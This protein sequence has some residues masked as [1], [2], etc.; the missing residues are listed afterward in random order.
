MLFPSWHH[1]VPVVAHRARK[2]DP[3]EAFHLI[4]K[5]RIRNAFMPPTALKMMRQVENPGR[6]HD[7][8]MRS[9]GCGGETLGAELLEWGK[10]VMG[11]TINEFYGQTEVNLVVGNCAEIMEIR[12]GSMGKPI[13]GHVAR[14]WMNPACRC[15]RVPWA[16]FPSNGPTR[17]CSFGSWDNLKATEE[18]YVGDWCLTGDLV[19]KDEDG[20]IWFVGRKDD[21]ITSE[22]YRIG[23]RRSKIA[24]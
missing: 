11:V 20:Y 17:L 22:G 18:K 6:R 3:E 4:A 14:L 10:E 12:P 16:R 1:G 7:F 24:Y 9:I 8:H 5:H 13:P 15:R 19:R 21:V 2:F 23:P